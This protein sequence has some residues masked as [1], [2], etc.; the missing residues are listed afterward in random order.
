MTGAEMLRRAAGIAVLAAVYFATAWIGLE[1][2]AVSGFAT[3]LWPPAGIA[4]AA[5][6]LF[7]S[8]LWPAVFIAAFL[9]VRTELSNLKV[10][11][12]T[13]CGLAV[14]AIVGHL[15]HLDY[16]RGLLQSWVDLPWPLS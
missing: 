12:L 14:L 4:L 11:F 9:R 6:L 13:A 10:A 8:R 15:I 7:G 5:L 2:D 1:L 16:P 3:L